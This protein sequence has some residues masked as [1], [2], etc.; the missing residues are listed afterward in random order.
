MCWLVSG[1]FIIM[2]TAA[3][4]GADSMLGTHL[5]PALLSSGVKV[6]SVGRSAKLDIH[7]DLE[8]GLLT[9]LSKNYNAEVIFHCAASFADDSREGIWQNFRIN[10]AGSLFVLE[11]AEHLKSNTII[12]AGSIFSNELLDPATFT[13]Y[14]FSKAQAEKI[15]DWG[16]T[17]LNRR[18]CS[19]RFSQIYDTIG[20][21]LRHQPWFGRIIAYTARGLDIN[22]P[23]S[24][25]VR[26][27]LHIDD[28]V[29]MMLTA[30]QSSIKGVYNVVN[31]ESLTYKEIADI[32]YQI[33]GKGGHVI[34]DPKKAPFRSIYFPKA[35]ETFR[36]L[37]KSTTISIA[38][39]IARI[40][41]QETWP[42][43]GPLD[44]T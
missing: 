29:W 2:K 22:M 8:K 19:L 28:V 38:E 12:Y 33:F 6:I 30:G 5:I 41:D 20:L 1:G 9:P 27:F 31:T 4:L 13:S 17:R 32:A 44:V 14:G 39:G 26:N 16:M 36:L 24:E 40:R 42:A 34:M 43:F 23:K 7:F 37:G 25:G 11:L 3:V 18:F 35:S 15:L 10:S 21:C